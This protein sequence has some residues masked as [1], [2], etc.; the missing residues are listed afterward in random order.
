M[1]DQLNG[2]DKEFFILLLQPSEI[3]RKTVFPFAN[4]WNMETQLII[5]LTQ[6]LIVGDYDI[7]DFITTKAFSL[8]L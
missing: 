5:F 3:M 1:C 4:H 8:T 6:N 2:E 7:S